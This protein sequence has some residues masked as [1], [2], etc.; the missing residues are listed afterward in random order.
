[1]CIYIR[2]K[3]QRLCFLLLSFSFLFSTGKDV[4]APFNIVTFSS[5]KRILMDDCLQYSWEEPLEKELLVFLLKRCRRFVIVSCGKLTNNI[6]S[7]NCRW[8]LSLRI[9]A[10]NVNVSSLLQAKAFDVHQLQLK[11]S[12]FDFLFTRIF[13]KTDNCTKFETLQNYFLFFFF[14]RKHKRIN[15]L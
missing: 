7:Y 11:V 15:P 12:P 1:M 14:F 9:T 6:D 2:K 3:Y 8:L 4:A 10:L 13:I 5:L